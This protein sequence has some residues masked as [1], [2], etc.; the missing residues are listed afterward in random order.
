MNRKSRLLQSVACAVVA[1]LPVLALA[2]PAYADSGSSTSGS[3]TSTSGSG[4]SSFVRVVVRA[5]HGSLDDAKK[6]VE[7]AGGDVDRIF[8]SIDGFQADVPAETLTNLW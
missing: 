5:K 2:A 6:L 7:K 4:S 1:A 8:S 3:G